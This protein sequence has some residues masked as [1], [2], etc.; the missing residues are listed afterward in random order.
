[1]FIG[2]GITT[3]QFHQEAI[4]DEDIRK[5]LSDAFASVD[6]R[7]GGLRLSSQSA[8]AQL[9]DERPFI[10]FLQESDPQH[11]GH[12]INCANDNF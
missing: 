2:E 8:G 4:F 5:I 7:K 9:G 12:L 6:D 3:L 1:M 11:I 10:Y